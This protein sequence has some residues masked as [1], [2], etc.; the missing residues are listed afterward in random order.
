MWCV[1]PFLISSNQIVKAFPRQ[2]WVGIL[3]FSLMSWSAVWFAPF[4]SL[5]L[6]APLLP[7]LTLSGESLSERRLISV[8]APLHYCP[9]PDSSIN[10]ISFKVLFMK[11]HVFQIHRLMSCNNYHIPLGG[12]KPLTQWVM[13]EWIDPTTLLR[14]VGFSKVMDTT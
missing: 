9:T 3:V 4:L 12:W 13:V 10:P 7:K 2:H 1:V 8:C 6:G 11:Q 14:R 5:S